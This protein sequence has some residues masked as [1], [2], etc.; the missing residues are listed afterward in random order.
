MEVP[1]TEQIPIIDS[2]PGMEVPLTVVPEVV[3]V[4]EL[5]QKRETAE[6]TTVYNCYTVIEGG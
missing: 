5:R 1:A 2:D 6:E 4:Q 3:Y